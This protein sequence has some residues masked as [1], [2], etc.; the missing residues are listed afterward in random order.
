MTF[1]GTSYFVWKIDHLPDWNDTIAMQ[2]VL[3]DGNVNSLWLKIADG[4]YAYRVSQTDTFLPIVKG[5]GVDVHAWVYSYGQYPADEARI[6]AEQCKRYGINHL[7]LDVE[8]DWKTK[9]ASSVL[10][11]LDELRARIPDV[12]LWLCSYRYPEY[13]YEIAWETWM[14]GVD[15][16]FPQVYWLGSDNAGQQLTWTLEDYRQLEKQFGISKKPFLPAGC[17]YPTSSWHPTNAHFDDFQATIKDYVASGEMQDGAVWFRLGT[18]M[19]ESYFS[20]IATQTWD[21]EPEP[22][23]PPEPPDEIVL[24]FRIETEDGIYAGRDIR[25]ARNAD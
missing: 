16:Y 14:S 10:I 12:T 9:S 3:I 24:D 22:P 4:T 21:Q 17:A 13:H 8:S 19:Q 23:E 1:F 6:A 2:S 5:A 11:Y 18:A 20:H 25:I 7:A 15:G